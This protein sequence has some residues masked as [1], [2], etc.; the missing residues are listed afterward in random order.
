MTFGPNSLVDREAVITLGPKPQV[1]LADVPVWDVRPVQTLGVARRILTTGPKTAVP[2]DAMLR[3]DSG[4]IKGE[5]VNHTART[6][7]DVQLVHPYGSGSQLVR[8]LAPGATATV[9]VAATAAAPAFAKGGVIFNGAMQGAPGIAALAAGQAISGP[10]DLA[11][12]AST[13]PIQ[14]LRV[15]GRPPAGSTRA[16]LVEPVVLQSADSL[17]GLPPQARL[18]SSYTGGASGQVD[19]YELELPRGLSGQVGLTSPMVYGPQ[20]ILTTGEVYDWDRGTWRSIS[21]Q[22]TPGSGPGQASP[23]APLT[24]AEISGGVVRVRVYPNGRYPV[25]L[26]ATS[27]P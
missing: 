10:G 11:L 22:S 1:L 14:T 23:A 26:S 5:V 12:V 3:L 19:A 6:I 7:R 15:D 2:I 16:M 18:V 21:L 20:A 13:D 25:F 27:L 4:R 9:D 8:T 17:S 24:A